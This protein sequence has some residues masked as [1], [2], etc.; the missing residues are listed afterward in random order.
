MAFVPKLRTDPNIAGKKSI[1]LKRKDS[2]ELAVSDCCCDDLE[3]VITYDWGQTTLYDLD[4]STRVIWSISGEESHGYQCANTEKFMEWVGGDDITK[5]GKEV[6]NVKVITAKKANE[7]PAP[8]SLDIDLYAW[9]YPYEG[10]TRGE[11]EPQT[12]GGDVIV[13]ATYGDQ[14]ATQTFNV[15]SRRTV[16][17]EPPYCAPTFLCTVSFASDGEIQ[18]L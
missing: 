14:T 15:T 16:D 5:A 11:G 10:D 3:L 13:T 9:W 1:V 2:G 12:G 4:T 6:V 7:W 8:S 17:D 18:I